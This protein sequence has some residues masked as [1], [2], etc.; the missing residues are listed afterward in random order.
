MQFRF[1]Y[2][3][4]IFVIINSLLMGYILGSMDF[5]NL[6]KS[7]NSL[8]LFLIAFF[9]LGIILLKSRVRIV[10]VPRKK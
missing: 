9:G 1:T 8:V 7:E 4:L 10:K 6:S 3:T 2:S 5:N